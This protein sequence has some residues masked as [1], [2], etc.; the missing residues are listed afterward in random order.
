MPPSFEPSVVRRSPFLEPSTA[1]SSERPF[2]VC[3]TH[4]CSDARRASVP[5]DRRRVSF[6]GD[7]TAF[8]YT[9]SAFVAARREADRLEA[10]RVAPIPSDVPD[11]GAGVECGVSGSGSV[12]QGLY[13][14][15]ISSRWGLRVHG[16]VDSRRGPDGTAARAY[17]LPTPYRPV[18]SGVAIG[19]H[20]PRSILRV[21]R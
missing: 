19:A 18:G 7:S 17:T 13:R 5:R 3:S 11:G 2:V 15:E 1:S 10:A 4:A 6:S 21:R 14:E 16:L 12:G 8:G 9:T 20:V